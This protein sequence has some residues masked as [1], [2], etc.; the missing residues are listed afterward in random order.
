MSRRAGE[1]DQRVFQR[2]SVNAKTPQLELRG[3][4]YFFGCGGL[5][6]LLLATASIIRACIQERCYR[7]SNGTISHRSVTTS[8]S[9]ELPK[10]VL[11]HR[12]D[13][14]LASVLEG[15]LAMPI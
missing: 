15:I 9:V 8:T 10:Q 12:R 14:S 5:L 13:Q 4:L 11:D 6:S 1:F 2:S 7:G 3:F